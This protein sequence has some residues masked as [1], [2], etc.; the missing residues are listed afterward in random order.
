MSDYTF[1]DTEAT[2]KIFSLKKRIRAVAGGTAAS[3]TISILFWIID[4]CQSSH[5][6]TVD[7]M[8]ESYPHL[9]GGAIKD[10][11]EI[12]KDRGY[13]DGNRWNST[14]HYY[15]FETGTVLKFI[16]VDRL[17]KAHGPRRDGLFINEC[18]N[19]PYNIYEQLEVRTREFVWLDWNP[20]NEFW[21]YT[22]ELNRLSREDYEFITLTYLDCLEVL[23]ENIVRSIESRRSNKNWWRVYGLG[24]LG[25]VEGRIYT[26]WEVIDEIPHYA[27]LE[28]YGLD[29]GYTNDPSA[30]I[31]IYKADMGYIFDEI[32][33][34][35]GM[36]NKDIADVFM[37]NFPALV[38]ADSAEPKSIAEIASYG[39]KIVGAQKGKDSINHG[40][41]YIQQQ[42]IAVT[43]RSVNLL[44]EYR[45]YMW[46]TDKDGKVINVPQDFMNHC[47][48]AIRYGMGTQR[49][50]VVTPT[51]VGGVKPLYPGMP[52]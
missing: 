45:N 15:T 11:Q 50:V 23:P 48:D 51:S 29:F 49:K 36:S 21:W 16:S 5:N 25:E 12:M 8:S 27:R 18:N 26:G 6:K 22:D 43:R 52:G 14:K 46:L 20:M 28:K 10:F 39:I 1:K 31:A 19:I 33:Y 41:Q 13:W 42:K 17:G 3:K 37:S 38:I 9:E 34:Q 47:M 32:L 4:Y 2:R 40:I 30:G 24:Q 35:K 7:V 44:K